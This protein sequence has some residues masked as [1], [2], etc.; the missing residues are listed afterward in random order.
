M[1]FSF[2]VSH[3]KTSCSRYFYSTT[4][5][6]LFLCPFFRVQSMIR[7]Y[8]IFGQSPEYDRQRTSAF[9]LV[10]QPCNGYVSSYTLH[11]SQSFYLH[12]DNRYSVTTL[13]D[14]IL[15][16]KVEEAKRLLRY[17]DKHATAIAVYLGFSSQSHFANVFKKY[18]GKP[19]SEYRKLHTK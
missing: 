13:T 2:S 19:P 3:T 4:R 14:F 12:V 1:L 11:R 5:G 7:G 9:P 8:F 15:K 18:T 10:C 16:E 6:F 17:T